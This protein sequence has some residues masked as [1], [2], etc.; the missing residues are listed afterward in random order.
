MKELETTGEGG[1][2]QRAN[3]SSILAVASSDF[4]YETQESVWVFFLRAGGF[5]SL[6]SFMRSV[7]VFAKAWQGCSASTFQLP[8]RSCFVS[9]FH[10]MEVLAVESASPAVPSMSR[11]T[12]AL[13]LWRHCIRFDRDP[14]VGQGWSHNR[15]QMMWGVHQLADG[16]LPPR[17]HPHPQTGSRVYVILSFSFFLWIAHPPGCWLH[18]PGTY[19]PG[20]MDKRGRWGTPGRGQGRR[21]WWGRHLG[22]G[23]QVP[24]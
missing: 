22:Q 1:G 2:L 5:E 24:E 15:R 11:M 20:R 8:L 14:I 17:V 12:M 9:R 18:H 19:P 21:T 6:I 3:D 16:T 7:T 4:T 13:A 23:K 10:V